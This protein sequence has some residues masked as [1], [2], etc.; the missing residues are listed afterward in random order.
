MPQ[1]VGVANGADNNPY[2]HHG[3][4]SQVGVGLNCAAYPRLTRQAVGTR[5]RRQTESAAKRRWMSALGGAV[6]GATLGKHHQELGALKG[7]WNDLL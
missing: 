3:P 7:R 4:L 6:C 5:P 2:L 1:H